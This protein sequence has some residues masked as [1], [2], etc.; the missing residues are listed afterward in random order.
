ML[1]N[2]LSY[3]Y[4]FTFFFILYWF[5]FNNRTKQNNLLFISSY[6][7]YGFW[8]WKFV[9]LLF[10]STFLD[11][12]TGKKI[13]EA[14]EKKNKKK[15]LII[16]LIINFSFLATFKYFNF[17][18]ESLSELFNLFGLKIDTLTLNVLLPV[19]ISFYTFHGV[20]YVLDIY[21]NKI[22]PEKK[23]ANY[24]VFVSFFP[25]LVAGPIERA[26]HLLPQ[27]NKNRTFDYVK[28][29]SGV[30]QILWG[31]FKK[32]V[33]ADTCALYSDTM[34]NNVYDH[35][36][37]ALLF[38][39]L[40]FSF[41]IYGDFSGYSDI[42]SG[43]ARLLGFELL[44]NFN[45][46]YFSKNI[47]EFWKKW[48]ISLSSW[49]RD[50]VYIPLGGNKSK[51]IRNILIIFILSGFWHGANWTFILWGGI[52][53]LFVIIA[54]KTYPVIQKFKLHEN[55]LLNTIR[56]FIT[57]V[58]ATLIWVLFRSES[59]EK[60][61]YFYSKIK[62]DLLILKYYKELFVFIYNK[63][64]MNLLLIILFFM[65]IEYIGRNN[66]YALEKIK[67]K[68][69]F[70]KMILFYTIFSL[71]IF[72]LYSIEYNPNFIYFQF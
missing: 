56:I 71:I 9:F 62:S 13:F 40:M 24:A 37:V 32:V 28:A 26:S 44:K 11:F 45:F 17:F 23:L 15:W 53:A 30:K 19:G 25:L 50:Y 35:N 70:F 42:A 58:L 10:F 60:A 63:S 3:L 47:A 12:Y 66:E 2:S 4:F 54:M 31:L 46:P 52:N 8:N 67:F 38:G 57:F 16:S 18:S 59:I 68:N 69:K 61:I 48:H 36:G 1:F 29:M 51:K 21:N 14:S 39:A 55:I 7:F 20:S 22:I 65:V 41:Q 6:I 64:I 49:F 43:S 27:I 72:Y 34:F 5:I 33:I